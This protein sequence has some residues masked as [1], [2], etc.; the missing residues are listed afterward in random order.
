MAPAIAGAT[1]DTILLD[2][3]GAKAPGQ[4]LPRRALASVVRVVWVLRGRSAAGGETHAFH[5]PPI[6]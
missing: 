4:R 6:S 3:S 5:D 1:L 2:R